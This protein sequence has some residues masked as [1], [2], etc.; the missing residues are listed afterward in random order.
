MEKP[1][2]EAKLVESITVK[3]KDRTERIVNVGFIIGMKELN[4]GHEIT[5]DFIGIND[6]NFY[7]LKQGI[8]FAMSAITSAVYEKATEKTVRW[9]TV[10]I[11]V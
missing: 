3:Y 1:S 9:K 8:L 4:P 11:C 5:L 2:N 10:K 7:P 6:N